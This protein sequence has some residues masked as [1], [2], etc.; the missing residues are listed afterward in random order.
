LDYIATGARKHAIK[1]EKRGRHLDFY[2]SSRKDQKQSQ[3]QRRKYDIMLSEELL[4]R[5]SAGKYPNS[6][7]I[8]VNV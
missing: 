8:N 2:A 4:K 6:F 3:I 5:I 7:E 1:E